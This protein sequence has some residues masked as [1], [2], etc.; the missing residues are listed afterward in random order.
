MGGSGMGM[1]NGGGQVE[2]GGGW[3]GGSTTLEVRN[4]TQLPPTQGVEWIAWIALPVTTPEYTHSSTHD[5]RR[6]SLPLA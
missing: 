2:G 5:T 6:P 3:G 1:W 4:E